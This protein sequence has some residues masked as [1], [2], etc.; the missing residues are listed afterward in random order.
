MKLSE[1]WWWRK[2]WLEPSSENET[3]RT[4]SFRLLRQVPLMKPVGKCVLSWMWLSLTLLLVCLL[5]SGCGTQPKD[6][7]PVISD[8]PKPVKLPAEFWQIQRRS[9]IGVLQ[10]V[11]DWSL[12]SGELLEK[13]TPK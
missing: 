1:T 8:A 4:K 3:R 11:E 2:M 10:K 5:L 13:E 12:S 9:S 6:E 7:L